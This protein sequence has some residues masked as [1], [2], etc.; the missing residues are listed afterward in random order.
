MSAATLRNP[1]E[2]LDTLAVTGAAVA[3]ALVFVVLSTS[4][5]GDKAPW[6]LIG[7]AAAP[8]IAIAVL[9]YPFMAVVIVFAT[10]P[11]GS[12]AVPGGLF[13]VVQA[14][15]LLS[16]GLVFARRVAR[17]HTPLPWIGE[18][19]W[20]TALLAWCLVSL[21]GALDSTLSIKQMGALFGGIVFATVML[22]SC[23]TMTD[24]RRALV[25]FVLVSAGTA[26]WALQHAGP[27]RAGY[28]GTYASG[29][30]QG[31]FNHPNDLAAFCAMGAL[32][33]A[34]SHSGRASAR[35]ACSR[36]RRS[37]RCSSASRS[38]S[39]AAHGSA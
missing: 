24:L 14:V 15:A 18:L 8:L 4:V 28:G 21:S 20:P 36:S 32:V 13:K 22:A 26:A 11:I 37:S 29:R 10:F 5:G 25:A 17:G 39:R 2:A 27:I 3:T 38:H 6:L 1:R 30:L 19:W 23:R 31:T 12:N 9:T 35:S 33:A 34:G 7:L 16:A